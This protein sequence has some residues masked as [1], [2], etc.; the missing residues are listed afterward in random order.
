MKLRVTRTLQVVQDV[1]L[2]SYY[3]MTVEQAV[4]YETDMSVSGVIESVDIAMETLK[5]EYIKVI[6]KIEVLDEDG[7][8]VSTTEVEHK[9]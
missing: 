8:V 9:E 2:T 6:T 7:N 1:D 5:P 3:G 4:A